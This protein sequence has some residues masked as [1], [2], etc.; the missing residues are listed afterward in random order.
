MTTLLVSEEGLALDSMRVSGEAFRHLFRA[1]RLVVG[2]R[3]RVVDG[4]GAARWATVGV[5]E[6]R[7][8]ELELGRPAPDNEPAREV[9]VF[10]APPKIGRAAWM[11][12]KL[13]EIGVR[14]LAIW[15][16]E[17]GPRSYGPAN[18]ERLMRVASAAVEQCERSRVPEIRQISWTEGLERLAAIEHRWLLKPG[19]PG[20]A[21]LEPDAGPVAVLV[22]P[23]GGWT[24][25]ELSDLAR[26]PCREIGLGPTTLRTETAAVVGA[27][28][29]LDAAPG[30][31]A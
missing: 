28:R 12:E 18:L 13:T 31:I 7:V 15:S 25:A 9:A 21:S 10:A 24:D 22:G 2:D 4:R 29:A 17:R 5:V 16:T 27:A 6:R 30:A 20:A 23:E 26:L 14:S 3:L 1:R 19:A 11:V 8:A